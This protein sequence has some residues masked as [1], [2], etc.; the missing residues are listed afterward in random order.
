[1]PIPRPLAPRRRVPHALAAV[2]AAAL[3]AGCTGST[4]PAAQAASGPGPSVI[5]PGRPGEEAETLTAEEAERRRPDDS[6]NS[7]DFAYIEMMIEH[8]GQALEMTRLVPGRVHSKRVRSLADRIE[9]G[10]KPEIGAMKAWL[11]NNGGPRGK[12]HDHDAM[13]GMATPRQ[14]ERL[15]EADG[16]EFDRLFLKLMTTHHAGAVSMATDVL[17]AGND[18]QVEEMAD[19]VIAT[20]STEIDR[21][22]DML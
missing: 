18:V 15:A 1:M 5:A 14:L 19:D 13:A 12:G 20:Q 10:Q 3:L 17:G 8:H 4:E 22:R 9:A 21:M 2:A 16:E 7:A 6:P 11:K